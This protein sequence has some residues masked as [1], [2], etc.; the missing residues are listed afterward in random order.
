MGK[1][2]NPFP[3]AIRQYETKGCRLQKAGSGTY[4]LYRGYPVKDPETGKRVTSPDTAIGKYS[5]KTGFIPAVNGRNL[6]C[7]EDNGSREQH[8]DGTDSVS[9]NLTPPVLSHASKCILAYDNTSLLKAIF[10]G[11]SDGC[12]ISC[13]KNRAE[14]RKE[15]KEANEMKKQ[16]H[17]LEELAAE[18]R[19][20]S[21]EESVPAPDADDQENSHL[22]DRKAAVINEIRSLTG[23][24]GNN[25]FAEFTL[26]LLEDILDEMAA[27]KE[28]RDMY[29]SSPSDF[30]RNSKINLE[31][32]V[33]FLM[34]NGALTLDKALFNQFSGT[35]DVPTASALCKQ[36]AKL[37]PEG[38]QYLFNSL[39]R[40]LASPFP[41]LWKGKWR[42]L[43]VDGTDT[44]VAYDPSLDSY[45][46]NGDGDGYNQLH[47]NCMYDVFGQYYCGCLIQPKGKTNEPGAARIMIGN[48]EFKEK[49][50]LMGDRGYGSLN[51][52]ETI[53][54]KE[55]LEFVIRV[56][57]NYI[58]EIKCLELKEQDVDISFEIVTR[59]TKENRKR[60]EEG[61]CKYLSGRSKYGKD[62]KDVAWDFEDGV[63][64]SIRVVRFQLSS[65]NWETLVTSL[66]RNEYS[67]EDLKELYHARYQIEYGFRYLKYSLA[68]SFYHSK[69]EDMIKQEIYAALCAYNICS[70]LIGYAAEMKKQMDEAIPEDKAPRL[71]YRI[72][73]TMG[74]YIIVDFL[75]KKGK[76]AYDLFSMITSYRVPV[77]PGRSFARK[78]RPRSWVPFFYRA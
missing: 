61:A 22:S 58:K 4:Y 70:A 15:R 13:R 19:D 3:D 43:A 11:G 47:V 5:E 23:K 26:M 76:V 50:I 60:I 24:A 45:V 48:T 27:D 72:N 69:K 53:K 29:F 1:K 37:K 2:R 20:I 36:R 67:L 12:G 7:T 55:N 62:K 33:I 32:L 51:L 38:M 31:E 28:H 78:V 59:Q 54:R 63:M 65:G 57:E 30:T 8:P 64:M 25:A 9:L 77:K 75:R 73:T 34:T 21:A 14:R 46:K 42:V 41:K 68:M 10:A 44:N 35:G 18:L 39:V 40:T 66:P 56:K 49:T 74:I 17:R 52:M 6:R 16:L 71:D